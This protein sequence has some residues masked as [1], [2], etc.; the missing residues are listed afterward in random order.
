MV[1]VKSEGKGLPNFEVAAVT[2]NAEG[3]YVTAADGRTDRFAAGAHDDSRMPYSDADIWKY[4]GGHWGFTSRGDR[5]LKALGLANAHSR[6]SAKS[7]VAAAVSGP[8][9]AGLSPWQPASP[10]A[11]PAASPPLSSP[12]SPAVEPDFAAR[13]KA[14]YGVTTEQPKVQ[15][16]HEPS[17]VERMRA[18][19]AGV[20]DRTTTVLQSEAEPDFA[21]RMKTRHRV[22]GGT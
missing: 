12:L 22:E 19:H 14:R 6:V 9:P 3:F 4:Q 18:R 21:A 11:P 13:A 15:A 16:G 7:F 1:S 5:K 2:V 10:T 17:F 20:N 8:A